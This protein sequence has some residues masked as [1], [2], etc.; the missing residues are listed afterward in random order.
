MRA[1]S[2]HP[3]GLWMEGIIS[4]QEVQEIIQDLQ[5]KDRMQFTPSTRHTT[6]AAQ[7]T[8][9]PALALM[10][11][12]GAVVNRLSTVSNHP[13]S[14]CNRSASWQCSAAPPTLPDL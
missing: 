11:C 14:A 9:P 6:F 5:V 4:P 12:E 2:R 3:A 7:N 1:A 8:C 10:L 13:A